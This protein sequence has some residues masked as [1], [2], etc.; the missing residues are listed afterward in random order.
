M[1][2]LRNTGYNALLII[3]KGSLVIDISFKMDHPA[4]LYR[5]RVGVPATVEHAS[6]TGGAE[7]AKAV[8]ETTQVRSIGF[9]VRSYLIY[10]CGRDRASLLLWT[11]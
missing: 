7:T 11:L 8:A 10:Y 5:L 4:A 9:F 1:T 2:L 3:C 6:E